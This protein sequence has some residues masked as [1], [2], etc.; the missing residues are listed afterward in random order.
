MLGF[1]AQSGGRCLLRLLI[2]R[3]DLE[4]PAWN[5]HIIAISISRL[6]Q[7]RWRTRGEG[8]W[9]SMPETSSN[10]VITKII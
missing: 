5:E 7:R 3:A 9:P 6:G 10:F 2:L 1:A 8:E 4:K